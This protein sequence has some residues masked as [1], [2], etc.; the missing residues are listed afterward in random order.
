M[1]YISI[2]C[3]KMNVPLNSIFSFKSVNIIDINLQKMDNIT[4]AIKEGKILL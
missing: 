1:I 4:K 3:Y 2:N